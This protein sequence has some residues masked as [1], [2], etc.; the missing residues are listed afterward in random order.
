M[1]KKINNQ[2]KELTQEE[3][4][5]LQKVI[6]P[7]P[8]LN[9]DGTV[10]LDEKREVVLEKPS[11]KLVDEVHDEI[12]ERSVNVGSVVQLIALFV[13]NLRNFTIQNLQGLADTVEIQKRLINEVA[14]PE[15][16]EKI[17]KKVLAEF[18]KQQEDNQEAYEKMTEALL[19]DVA[20]T[21]N[22]QKGK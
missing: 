8:R 12:F 6:S 5:K 14:G 17:T 15:K 11:K 9:A 13:G 21:L 2:P 20:N 3:F 7:K 4:E 16:A 1:T 19:D 10:K 18:K 22:E